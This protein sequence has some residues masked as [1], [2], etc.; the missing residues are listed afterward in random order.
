MT[1]AW[2]GTFQSKYMQMYRTYIICLN[3]LY[4]LFLLRTEPTKIHR[5][6][7]LQMTLK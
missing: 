2:H 3:P 4:V 5:L 6:L 1:L 7:S